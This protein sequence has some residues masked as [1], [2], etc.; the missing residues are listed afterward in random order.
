MIAATRTVLFAAVL[1]GVSL[2]TACDAN[3]APGSA[4]SAKKAEPTVISSAIQKAI[5]EAQQEIAEGNITVSKDEHGAGK[6]AEITPKG[7]LLIDGRA[8]AVTP[9]QRA[10]LLEYRG[11]VVAVAT[12]GMHIGMESADL[13]TKAVAE[14]LK[15][16]FTGNTDEGE[17]HVE[18]EADKVRTAAQQLC[19][20]LPG[21]LASQQKLAAA[22][23]EFQPYATMEA[24]DVDDCWKETRDHETASAEAEASKR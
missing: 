10:L 5:G 13:A 7:D 12:A 21:M 9:A 4:P 15:G 23:P 20:H 16:V 8:V 17:K 6:K 22:L 18:A 19:T 24:D 1:G 2:L 3:P 11:H 14:S